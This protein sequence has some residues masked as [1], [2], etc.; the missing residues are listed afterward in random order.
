MT[1]NKLELEEAKKAIVST[2]YKCEKAFPKLKESSA[3]QTLLKNRIKALRLAVE[4][5]EKELAIFNASYRE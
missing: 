3:Q 1:Y 2:I 4:L 5:I